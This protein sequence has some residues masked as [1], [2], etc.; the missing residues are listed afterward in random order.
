MK[1]E[2]NYLTGIKDIDN[3]IDDFREYFLIKRKIKNV[4]RIRICPR[5]SIFFNSA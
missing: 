2:I 1:S 3:I 4:K 5:D